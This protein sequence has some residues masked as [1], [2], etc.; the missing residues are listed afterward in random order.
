MSA[1][2][3]EKRQKDNPKDKIQIDN[4]NQKFQLPGKDPKPFQKFSAPNNF[5]GAPSKSFSTFHRRSGK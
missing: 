4:K 3:D 1:N 2:K 5:G